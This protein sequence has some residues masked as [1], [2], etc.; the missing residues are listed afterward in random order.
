M[1]RLFNALKALFWG[2]TKPGYALLGIQNVMFARRGFRYSAGW[3]KKQQNDAKSISKPNRMKEFFDS[4]TEGNGVWKFEHYFDIYERHFSK[5]VGKEVHIVE[6]GIFSGGS[7]AMWRHYF[8]DKCKVYGVDIMKECLSYE[9][10]YTKIFIGDQE[11]RNFWRTFKERVPKVD[12]L[13]DDG[14]HL[15][16]QQIATLEEMLPHLGPGGVYMCEDVSGERNKFAAYISGLQNSLNHKNSLSSDKQ[17][18][19]CT[20][21]QQQISSVHQYPYLFV[22]EKNEILVE[23]LS[24]PRHGTIWGSYFVPDGVS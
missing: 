13:V 23:S 6:V 9:N 18:S 14:G 4:N 11:D 5:F 8:G 17:Q 24:A 16:G 7:L 22:I 20:A 3:E 21:F 15:P 19:K 1:K 10:E 12:I 2:V